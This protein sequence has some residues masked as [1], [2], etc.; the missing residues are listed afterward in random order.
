[1]SDDPGHLELTRRRLFGSLLTLGAAGSATGAGTYALFSDTET[2][3]GNS[4]QAGTIDLVLSEDG[5][6]YSDGVSDSLSAVGSA[7]LASIKPGDEY[8]LTIYAKNTG[9]LDADHA[10]VDFRYEE[11]EA[12]NG[13]DEGDTA[14]NSADGFAEQITVTSLVYQP[15]GN[16]S[17]SL[18]DELVDENGNGRIDL[19][20]LAH[21][22]NDD[23]LDDLAAP[24][25]NGGSVET[26]SVGFKFADDRAN[27]DVQGD[28]LSMTV[29]MALFQDA[30]Q[31][32]EL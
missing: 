11:T 3:S 15:N 12:S 14:P 8:S 6:S 13:S 7:N 19:A 29:E 21:A 28:K 23:V 20:D 16:Q 24:D 2:S 10:E 31:D 26:L 9:S 5:T 18:T 22:S 17:F 30:S 25:S 4:V 1:M 27:N 32:I